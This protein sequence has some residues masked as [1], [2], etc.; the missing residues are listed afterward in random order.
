MGLSRPDTSS[1]FLFIGV[2]FIGILAVILIWT[3]RRRHTR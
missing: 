3:G 2:I 1:I